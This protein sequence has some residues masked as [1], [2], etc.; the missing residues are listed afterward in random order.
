MANSSGA[1]ILSK[2]GQD[3]YQG[4]DRNHGTSRILRSATPDVVFPDSRGNTPE[5]GLEK[6]SG[7]LSF[8]IGPLASTLAMF[9]GAMSNQAAKPSSLGVAHCN[10]LLIQAS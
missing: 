3:H 1:G 10:C 5:I 8:R 7:Q 2:K 9:P 4:Q 6:L